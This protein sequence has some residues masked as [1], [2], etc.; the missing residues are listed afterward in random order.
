[1]SY[2]RLCRDEAQDIG[3]DDPASRA[4]PVKVGG[5][6]AEHG[7]EDGAVRVGEEDA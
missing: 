6:G 5:D 7:Q 4:E 3:R 1:M 2:Q